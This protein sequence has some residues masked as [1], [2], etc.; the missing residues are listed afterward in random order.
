MRISTNSLFEGAAARLTDLQSKVDQIAQQV[1]SGRKLFTPSDDPIASAQALLLEQ[2]SAVNSQYAKNRSSLENTLG[3]V[4]G[5]L[6]SVSETL[7]SI[8]E[9][10]VS[11]GNGSY[12]DTELSAIATALM[13]QRDQLISL[14]NATDGAGHYLFSGNQTLTLPFTKNPDGSVTYHG[15]SSQS[16]VQVDTSRQMDTGVSGSTLFP[17]GG[18]IFNKLQNAIT[19]LQTPNLSMADRNA[20]LTDLGNSFSTTLKNVSNAS[21]SV[22]IRLKEL[23]SLNTLGG[24]RDLQYAQTLSNLQDLDYN[25]ALSDLTRQ[26]MALQAAQKTFTQTSSLSLFNYMN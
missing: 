16:K 7:Q 8:N 13:G 12:S 22:G 21:G 11:A 23:D 2:S 24:G 10:V 14:A 25:K 6:S 9:Q 5:T 19:K 17:G 4:D 1:S 15:D 26:Q 20:A 3:I 18:D